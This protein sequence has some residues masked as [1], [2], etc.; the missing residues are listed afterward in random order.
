MNPADGAVWNKKGF[1]LEV[2]FGARPALLVVD[3]INGFTDP[4]SPLGADASAQIEASNRLIAVARRAGV[5]VIFSTIAYEDER[6]A[7][8]WL[9]KI[10][11]LGVLRARTDAVEPDARLDRR[12]SDPLLHKRFASC[13][14]ETDLPEYL[15]AGRIDT[16]IVCGCSTSGCVR[17]TVVDACQW[18]LRVHVA[19][20]ATCDRWDAAH[21]Q[22]LADIA[23]KYGDVRSVAE[24]ADYLG[25]IS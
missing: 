11:G 8:V 12:P 10:A 15:R 6:E 21:A 18:G 24:I 4:A 23:M 2:G 20:D 19:E 9:Q 22:S 1:G 17:A 5:P 7:G 14:F 13:F 3:L 16:L 25:G